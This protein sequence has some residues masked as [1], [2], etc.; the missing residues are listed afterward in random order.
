MKGPRFDVTTSENCL[1][2]TTCARH[3]S[4]RFFSFDAIGETIIPRKRVGVVDFVVTL[5]R[6]IKSVVTGQAPVTLEGKS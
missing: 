3:D 5:T 2:L 6:T 1:S 4:V